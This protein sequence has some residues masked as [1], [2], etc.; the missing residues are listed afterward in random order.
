M[1]DI[2][3]QEEIQGLLSAVDNT[4]KIKQEIK[5]TSLVDVLKRE[6]AD[7]LKKDINNIQHKVEW[8]SRENKSTNE[9]VK[10]IIENQKPT[11]KHKVIL[12]SLLNR[13]IIT[14]NGKYDYLGIIKHLVA[15]SD[16]ARKEGILALENV[17]EMTKNKLMKRGIALAVDGTEPSL[18]RE[19]LQNDVNENKRRSELSIMVYSV[20]SN[21]LFVLGILTTMSATILFN[22]FEY[23][24]LLPATLGLF[25]KYIV[26]DCVI[27][28]KKLNIQKDIVLGKIIVSGVMSI[29]DGNNPRIVEQKLLMFLPEQKRRGL[30]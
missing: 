14:I 28:L 20:L 16:K 4:D 2:L 29:Q 12:S 22:K 27:W 19:V 6:V 3:S 15:F 24:M 13:N 30:L 17:N 26:F 1:S 23:F 5:E 10:A 21:F 18:I 7:S 25:V 8:L 9:T 11:K